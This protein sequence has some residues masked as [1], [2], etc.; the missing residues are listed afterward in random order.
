M[1]PPAL[2]RRFPTAAAAH[3]V[4]RRAGCTPLLA[5]VVAGLMLTG[6]GC[7]TAPADKSDRAGTTETSKQF[8]LVGLNLTMIKV[9]PGTFTMGHPPDNVAENDETTLTEVT[10]TK[11]FWLGATELT[12]GQWR[13]FADA[14]GYRTQPEITGAG[15]WAWVGGA[16]SYEQQPGTS[17][18]NPGR[19]E[20]LDENLP[21]SG[22]NWDDAQAF[23]AWLTARER[24]AGRLPAGYVFSLP[25]EAQWEYA[26]KAGTGEVD[27][28]NPDEVAWH[29]G[30]S[31]MAAHP[32]GL[33]K[34]NAWGFYDMVGN[35]WE[36]C[37]DWYA[38]LFPGGHVVDFVSAEPTGG[39]QKIHN[40]RGNSF[41]GSG[42]HN[43]GLTNRWG[44][45]PNR[46]GYRATLGFR[47]ALVS[48]GP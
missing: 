28:A 26:A 20:K 29:G 4:S 6:G 47:L 44:T 21:V 38:P 36:W 18:R 33:K 9:L 37:Q 41:S 43:T 39:A 14:T 23:C 2:S 34:A 19:V 48:S 1:L 46:D 24:A 45:T 31:G 25:T 16:A 13:Q 40:I 8:T 27:S 22:V 5:L 30:N 17:W 12:V 42:V 32:V 35:L 7:A 10:L 11:A 15:M 3:P